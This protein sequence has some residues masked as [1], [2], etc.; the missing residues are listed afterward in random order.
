MKWFF[1]KKIQ[2]PKYNT[3]IYNTNNSTHMYK[4]ELKYIQ[5]IFKWCRKDQSN[6]MFRFGLYLFIIMILSILSSRT[7]AKM[8][9]HYNPHPHYILWYTQFQKHSH[10]LHLTCYLAWNKTSHGEHMLWMMGNLILWCS[11]NVNEIQMNIWL[12]SIIYGD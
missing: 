5:H 7:Q 10:Q 9:L 1:L 11:D 8:Q 2:H 3:K 4:E 12:Y 6:N